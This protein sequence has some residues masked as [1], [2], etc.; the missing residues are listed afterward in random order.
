MNDNPVLVLHKHVI[1]R[2]KALELIFKD[3]KTGSAPLL[4]VR[5]YRRIYGIFMARFKVISPINDK[6]TFYNIIKYLDI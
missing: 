5:P 4:G 3:M 1:Y 6:S 2:W